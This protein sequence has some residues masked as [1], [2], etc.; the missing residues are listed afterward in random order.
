VSPS[1][2][3]AVL[4]PIRELRESRHLPAAA[5]AV[6]EKDRLGLPTGDPGAARAVEEGLAWLCRAQDHSRSHDG[7]VARDYSLLRGWN[8]SYPET[9]GYIVPTF[10]E[11]YRRTGNPDFQ[12]RAFRMLDWLCSIQMPGGGF[13]GGLIDSQPRVPVIF[14]TG[15]I[16]IGL[17]AGAALR[18]AYRKAMCDAADWLRDVQDPDGCWRKHPTPFAA[19]GEKTYETHVSWGL[20]EAARLEPNRGYAEAAL[21][22]VRWAL[23]WQKQN[24]WFD[25]C[26]LEDPV[27]PLTHTLGYVLRGVIEAHRYTQDAEFLLAARKTADGLL[28]ASRPDGYLPGRLSS[29]WRPAVDWVCLTGTVQI[30]YCWLYLSQTT[31][32]NRYRDAAL[33]ANSYVRRTMLIDGPPEQRGGIKGSF[34]VT[35][36]YGRFEYLNWACKF[37]VDANLCEQ[38]LRADSK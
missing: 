10:L 4:K 2:L 11:A 25:R 17:A 29:D 15:Q 19:P 28:S 5:K 18:N 23:G 24:G 32:E 26:C 3:E 34:P 13:Q 22:N 31:G 33:K 20:F 6:R 16:L 37:F 7:G 8:S 36:G 14:N 21:R 30:A 9:T 1:P 35:G 38:D 12:V 27:S